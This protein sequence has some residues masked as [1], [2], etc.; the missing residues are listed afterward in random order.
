M[1]QTLSRTWD[2]CRRLCPARVQRA[3][4]GVFFS[5]VIQ[6]M[7]F[8]ERRCG[9]VHSGITPTQYLERFGGFGGTRDIGF[10]IWQVALCMNHMMED[11]LPAAKDAL[12]LQTAMDGGKM[13][14]GLLL[15]GPSGG[16]ASEPLQR[17][18]SGPDCKPPPVCTN[19]KPAL[20][21]KGVAVPERNG[22]HSNPAGGGDIP[23]AACHTCRQFHNGHS[24][25]EGKGKRRRCKSKSHSSACCDRRG[26]VKK[27]IADE[28]HFTDEVAFV[29]IL[30]ALP[31]LILSTRT[32]TPFLAFLARSM[33]ACSTDS[34]PS[35]AVCPST[36]TV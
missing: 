36:W 6:S 30:A 10:I 20:G 13:E 14:V 2:P 21:H 27:P 19:C 16:S 26:T 24:Q 35:S 28:D 32:R 25:E 8:P 15:A 33:H 18:I 11:N 5:S 12:S 1:V 29:K 3:H 17:P 23:K 31:R 34:G 9:D 22:C 4:K 7:A